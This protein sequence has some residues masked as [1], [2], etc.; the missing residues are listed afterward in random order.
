MKK[1]GLKIWSFFIDLNFSDDNYELNPKNFKEL[2]QIIEYF[3]F[4]NSNSEPILFRGHKDKGYLLDSTFSRSL[5]EGQGILKT[6]RYPDQVLQ[7]KTYQHK[8]ATQ[9]VEKCNKVQYS[10]KLRELSSKGCS[11]HFELCR[12]AQQNPEDSKFFDLSPKGTN[13]IDFTKDPLKAL[14]FANKGSRQGALFLVWQCNTGKS[15]RTSGEEIINQLQAAVAKEPYEE[16]G[17]LPLLLFPKHQIK[18][19]L[20][21]KPITQEAVYFVQTDFRFD[22]ELCWRRLSEETGKRVYIKIVLPIGYKNHINYYLKSKGITEEYL[23]PPTCFDEEN[24]IC[25]S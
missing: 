19:L 5:K 24:L 17:S 23:F 21:P 22:L 25:C 7:D 3:Q 6:S 15:F 12:N 10:P 20:D 13:L 14:F 4:L 18:D 16:Y 1:K 8:C 9:W 11:F 2:I